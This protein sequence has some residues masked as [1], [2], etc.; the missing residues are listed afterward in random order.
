MQSD[1]KLPTCITR[2]PG[3]ALNARWLHALDSNGQQ[4]GQR[5]R[6]TEMLSDEW[7]ISPLPGFFRKRRLGHTN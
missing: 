6:T 5:P 7:K 3:K 2:K 4:L 1:K